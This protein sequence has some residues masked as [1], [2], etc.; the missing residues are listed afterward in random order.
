M[1]RD[2]AKRDVPLRLFERVLLLLNELSLVVPVS[3][4]TGE[5]L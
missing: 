1:P 5:D 4:E 3:G 2:G